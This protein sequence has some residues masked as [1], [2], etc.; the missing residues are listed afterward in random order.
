MVSRIDCEMFVR[1]TKDIQ[2][3]S[4][5]DENLL[6]PNYE[7]RRGCE[8]VLTVLNSHESIEVEELEYSKLCHIS[9]FPIRH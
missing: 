2:F 8:N 9:Y 4:F 1:V 7:A 3:K 6:S 5:R